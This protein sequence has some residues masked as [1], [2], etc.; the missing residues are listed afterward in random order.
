M[1]TKSKR[2]SDAIEQQL[3]YMIISL[4]LA[5]GTMISEA[6]LM[7][8]LKCGRTPLREALQ[9]LI[10][11]YLIVS[12]PRKGIFIAELNLLDYIQLIEAVAHLES[13]AAGLAA[14]RASEA[15]IDELEKIVQA[16]VKASQADKILEI[17]ELD[18]S[19]HHAMAQYARN[20]YLLD[21]TARLHH[22]TSRFIYLAMKNGLKTGVSL[23]E[24]LEIINAIR[25][26]DKV[27]A[28]QNTYMHTIHAKERILAAL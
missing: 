8:K 25:S 18:Y 1:K 13:L 28:S 14:E 26:R 15:E 5:P 23:D 10:Q 2:A 4:E 9:R 12:V 17:V 27:V 21:M 7:E 6:E 20:R 19:F 22:L 3:H 24:H 16:A 11:Q